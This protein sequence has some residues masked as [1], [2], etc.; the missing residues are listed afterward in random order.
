M[1]SLL[2]VRWPPSTMGLT[3]EDLKIKYLFQTG[4]WCG[5]TSDKK[6]MKILQHTRW[7]QRLWIVWESMRTVFP[8]SSGKKKYQ[9]L[10]GG[11]GNP[12]VWP[13]L[14]KEAFTGKRHSPYLHTRIRMRYDVTLDSI[15]CISEADHA[16]ITLRERNSRRP[17]K[18]SWTEN[19]MIRSISSD[20][21]DD[22][23][24][25]SWMISTGLQVIQR[26]NSSTR[27]PLSKSYDRSCYTLFK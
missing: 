20:Y 23:R 6:R 15:Q 21:V 3:V 22:H 8:L 14:W 25:G 24:Y 2:Y 18:S 27:K 1:W 10:S 5:I 26:S 16:H 17:V 11:S 19:G 4:M 13:P 9:K 7:W 12:A